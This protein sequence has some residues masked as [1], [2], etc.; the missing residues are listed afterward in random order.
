MATTITWGVPLFCDVTGAPLRI[1]TRVR[2]VADS[3]DQTVDERFL[4]RTGVVR[5]LLFDAPQQFPHDPLIIVSVEGLGDDVF[6][7]GELSPDA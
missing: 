2:V 7:A 1:A 4:G 6:F 3:D 5:G